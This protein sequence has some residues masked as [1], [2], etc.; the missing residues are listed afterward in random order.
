M[1]ALI[2][3]IRERQLITV[4]TAMSVPFT[5][6]SLDVGDVLLQA[7]DGAPLLVAERKT[8][9]D[10][11][12]SIKDGRYREQRTRLMA[13]RG[14]GVAVLYILEGST[15]EDT[16]QRMMSR[17]LLRYGMPILQTTSVQDTA[18]WCRLLLKQISDDITVFHPEGL[19]AEV[20]GAMA[21]YT[22]TF[23]TVKKGNKTAGT[24]AI[25]MLS[26]VPGLGAKRVQ[27]LLELKTISQLCLM[28][29]AE[30][31]DLEV[32]G[33][34]IGLPVATTLKEALG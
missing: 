24:T 23:S 29:A 2:I 5:T 1:P 8:Y 19:A 10:F 9:A 28:T 12:S 15:T 4:L 22:A 16:L 14:Q 34:R 30:V 18:N 26:T 6:A 17:L 20:A 3:D 13:T 25:A 11:A 31:G 27:G 32:G 7:D 33:R 21:T